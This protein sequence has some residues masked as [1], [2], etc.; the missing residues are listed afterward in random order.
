M[1]RLFQK[2]VRNTMND[3]LLF[4]STVPKRDLSPSTEATPI[5]EIY[6]RKLEERLRNHSIPFVCLLGETEIL[7]TSR[8]ASISRLSYLISLPISK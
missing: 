7:Q 3:T 1:T 2:V 6:L 8:Y 4:S 5:S